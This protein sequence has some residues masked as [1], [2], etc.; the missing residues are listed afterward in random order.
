MDGYGSQPS[1]EPGVSSD[2]AAVDIQ[3]TPFA[4]ETAEE[5]LAAS[6]NG[7]GPMLWPV[8]AME[9]RYTTVGLVHGPAPVATISMPIRAITALSNGKST[10]A[11][12]TSQVTVVQS[13]PS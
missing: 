7:Q 1:V 5:T 2:G 11:A 6:S 10:T 13:L 8:T 4:A 12:P 9:S 3:R